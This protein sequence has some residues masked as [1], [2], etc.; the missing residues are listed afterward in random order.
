MSKG[1]KIIIISV[2]IVCGILVLLSLS[3][4]NSKA[5]NVKTYKVE[6]GEIKSYL[7]TTGVIKSKN[8]KEYYGSQLKI[9]KINVN[10]G[11]MVKKGDTLVVFDSS[12]IQNNVKQAQIQYDNAILQKQDLLNQKKKIDDTL[13][14]FNNQI[15][16]LQKQVETLNGD[17]NPLNITKIEQ[18]NMQ[19]EQLKTSKNN[20]QT[21]SAEKLKQADNTVAL[22]KVALDSANSKLNSVGGNI[23]A[24]FDGVVTSINGT[25][26]GIAT[27]AAPIVVI[28]D[29]SDLKIVVSLGKADVQK[30]QLNQQA[31]VKAGGKSYKGKV[32]F[33]S[34]A[35]KKNISVASTSND[36]TLDAEINLEE[37][38]ENL[39]IEFDADVDILLGE[40]KDVIV[41]PNEALKTVKG[42]KYLVYVV[43]EKGKA[44]EKE[45]KIGL[46]SE[47]NSEVINGITEGEKIIL[48]P[49]ASIT[50]GIAVKEK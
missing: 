42:G 24:D 14:N 12:D 50:N 38:G 18:L 36:V 1:K 11:D 39:K 22:A 33:I 31:I 29:L 45:V 16:S 3:K 4:N 48:N 49:N 25:E 5:V 23:I 7:S 32:V 27:A 41:I 34:P 35:G 44:I 2:L 26:G 20:V 10:I 15:E 8:I 30:I 9:S 40:K 28:Q 17:N 46:Q 37:N 13:V 19:I 43:D 6:K 21:I 47:M